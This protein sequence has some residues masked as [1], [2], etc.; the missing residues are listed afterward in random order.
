VKVAIAISP[1][2]WTITFE[3]AARRGPNADNTRVQAP[4]LAKLVRFF[5]GRIFTKDKE[6]AKSNWAQPLTQLQQ[7]CQFTR[8]V[9]RNCA[10]MSFDADA[11]YD[12]LAVAELFAVMV[13]Y[14]SDDV[15]DACRTSSA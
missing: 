3:A 14:A 12:A 13:L 6:V 11:A 15:V 2:P 1:V 7:S 10:D 4:G 9:L 8:A 5:L